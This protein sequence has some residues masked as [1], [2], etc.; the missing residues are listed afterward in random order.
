MLTR[1]RHWLA[2]NLIISGIGLLPSGMAKESLKQRFDEWADD[3]LDD[4]APSSR[5]GINVVVRRSPQGLYIATSP[6]LPGLLVATADHGELYEAVA[7]QVR[8]L[9]AAGDT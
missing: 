1:L 9:M 6:D 5:K 4:K 2:A 7:E 8:M 3:T